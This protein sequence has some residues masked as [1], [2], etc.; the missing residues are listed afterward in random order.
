MKYCLVE[1]VDEKS[2]ELVLATWVVGKYCF[3]PP[4]PGCQTAITNCYEPKESWKK[5][6]IIIKGTFDNYEDGRRKL[7]M[8]EYS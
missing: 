5:Y 2:I 3:W 1:F 7:P 6:H 4:G 8:A